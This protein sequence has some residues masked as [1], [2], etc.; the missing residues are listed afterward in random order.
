MDRLKTIS[1]KDL[2]AMALPDFCPRCFWIERHIGKSP[3]IFP[4]IF[5][6]LDSVSKKAA[7]LA[8]D[9]KQRVPKWLPIKGAVNIVKGS[10]RY[11]S[12]IK[13]GDWNLVG[14]PDD[15]LEFKTKNGE[16]GI[17]DMALRRKATSAQ[18]RPDDILEFK[19]KKG[20]NGDYEYNIIDYKTAKISK[21]QDEL[22]PMYEIQ[23][24]VYAFLVEQY[25]LSPVTKLSLV[26]C[27][28][29]SDL[30][31][32]DKFNLG[33]NTQSFDVKINKQK[34]FDLLVK[35]REIVDKKELPEPYYKCKGIC[36]WAKKY[37]KKT[38]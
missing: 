12:H 27:E 20:K 28:P 9:E 36:Q 29:K 14:M 15:I 37:G 13:Y 33:F 25:G 22:F 24:N 21:K 17:K 11:T 1:A 2:G 18:R 7:H 23:L 30:D 31:N 19:G 16:K 26:Y 6:T 32:F 5:S 10:L 38:K 8:F 35:A 3:S 34:V 4:G